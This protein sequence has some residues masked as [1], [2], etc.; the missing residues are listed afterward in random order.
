MKRINGGRLI[1]LRTTMLLHGE[2]GHEFAYFFPLGVRELS[3]FG[4]RLNVARHHST[5]FSARLLQ[6]A[7]GNQER[8]VRNTIEL[9]KLLKHVWRGLCRKP[10]FELRQVLVGNASLTLDFA[11]AYVATFHLSQSFEFQRKL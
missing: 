3:S 5:F 11:Q 10:A 4:D 8:L 7:R 1:L 6:I 9:C 2:K